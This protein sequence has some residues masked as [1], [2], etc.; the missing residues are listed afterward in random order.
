MT[1]G[2]RPH[3]GDERSPPL[4]DAAGPG[5][6]LPPGAE[7]DVRAL[8]SSADLRR[9]IFSNLLRKT[10]YGLGAGLVLGLLVFRQRK[11]SICL[12]TGVGLGMG[13][14]EGLHMMR[15]RDPAGRCSGTLRAGC[16]VTRHAGG[17]SGAPPSEAAHPGIE[18]PGTEERR[19]RA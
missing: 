5:P 18:T 15:T 3:E 1:N 7:E 2:H 6:H 14:S 4:R 12:A 17:L 10:G 8:A 16:P 13:V 19:P 11:A 9:A